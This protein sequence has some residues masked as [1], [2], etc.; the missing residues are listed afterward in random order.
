LVIVQVQS[1]SLELGSQETGVV[2]VRIGDDDAALLLMRQH[3]R[4]L[5]GGGREVGSWRQV[6]GP[7]P[8]AIN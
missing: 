1:D 5:S 7:L 4:S 2:Y 6:H 8:A 3:G